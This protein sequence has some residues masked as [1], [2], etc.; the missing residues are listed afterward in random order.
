VTIGGAQKPAVRI[1]LDPR[2]VAARGL[3]LDNVRATIVGSTVNA[4]KGP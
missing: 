4:P 2:K 3:Q 1:R